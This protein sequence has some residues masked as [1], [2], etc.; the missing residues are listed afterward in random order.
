MSASEN[1]SKER[2][3]HPLPLALPSQ[4]AEPT[5]QIK[6]PEVIVS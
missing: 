6:A 3:A 1:R 5:R 4:I 2:T